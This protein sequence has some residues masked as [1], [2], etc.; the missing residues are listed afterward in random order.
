MATEYNINAELLGYATIQPSDIIILGKSDSK[1][2]G[3]YGGNELD[4]WRL[5]P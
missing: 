1:A 3:V 2:K 4:W 5:A